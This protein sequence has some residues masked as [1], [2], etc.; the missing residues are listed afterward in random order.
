MSRAESDPP[1]ADREVREELDRMEA[2][3]ELPDAEESAERDEDPEE[4][5]EGEAPTG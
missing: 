2:E 1:P 3:R 5:T 4:Q